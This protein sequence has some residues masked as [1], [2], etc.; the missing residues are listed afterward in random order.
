M[1]IN[2]G[3]YMINYASVQNSNNLT[4]NITIS[5]SSTNQNYSFLQ[6][7]AIKNFPISFTNVT[8]TNN[9]RISYRYIF[10]G[11]FINLTLQLVVK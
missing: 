1:Q 6:A 4:A 2:Q 5:K 7:F 9:S 8:W 10:Q 11:L 3:K